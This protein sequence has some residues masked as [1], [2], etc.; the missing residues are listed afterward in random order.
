MLNPDLKLMLGSDGS[1]SVNDDSM[2]RIKSEDNDEKLSSDNEYPI[3]QISFEYMYKNIIAKDAD[4][5]EGWVDI[6]LDNEQDDIVEAV[7]SF[8]F[9]SCSAL[10]L[11]VRNESKEILHICIRHD[12]AC[13]QDIEFIDNQID[14]R[15][16]WIKEHY[17]QNVNIYFAIAHA[18]SDYYDELREHEE[19]EDCE[20]YFDS[21]RKYVE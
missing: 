4:M 9:S 13:D 5:S 17:G 1:N 19:P 8:G 11:I 10:I 3:R 2:T 16:T 12:P 18:H 6:E 20:K 7:C 14:E 21:N 15:T